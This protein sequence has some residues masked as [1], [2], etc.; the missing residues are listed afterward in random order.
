MWVIRQTSSWRIHSTLDVHGFPMPA[1]IQT[2][3]VSLASGI[4]QIQQMQTALARRD[5]SCTYLAHHELE[6]V[7]IITITIIVCTK[8]RTLPQWPNRLKSWPKLCHSMPSWFQSNPT[9]PHASCLVSPLQ[10]RCWASP[11]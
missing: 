10:T 9:K 6:S 8:S 5:L 7:F 2:G 4:V 1:L 11:A 3:H